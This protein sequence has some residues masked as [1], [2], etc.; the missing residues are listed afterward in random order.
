M[1]SQHPNESGITPHG[2]T[3]FEYVVR[4]LNLSLEEYAGSRELKEWVRKNKDHKYVPL[5]LLE[6]W[7]LE[8]NLDIAA[9][10]KKPPKRAA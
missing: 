6:L 8:V 3:T 5:Y 1:S 7:G 10:M 4:R 9:G 2:E